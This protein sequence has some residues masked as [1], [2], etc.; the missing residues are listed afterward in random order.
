[1]KKTLLGLAMTL[2]LLSACTGGSGGNT[3]NGNTTN[4]TPT[5]GGF[6]DT[7]L[8]GSADTGS[9]SSVSE[10]YI[11]SNKT[12]ANIEGEGFFVKIDEAKEIF[13]AS[14]FLDNPH[15]I[16]NIRRK[17]L[18]VVRGVNHFDYISSDP[19]TVFMETKQ[20]LDAEN[21]I[22]SE[23]EYKALAK[24]VRALAHEKNISLVYYKDIRFSL[25]EVGFLCSAISSIDE[26]TE[27]TGGSV[28]V[29]AVHFSNDTQ[30]LNLGLGTITE[31]GT[32]LLMDFRASVQACA[33]SEKDIV[34]SDLQFQ[35]QIYTFA[36]TLSGWVANISGVTI[37][38]IP[39]L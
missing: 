20:S 35:E 25:T 4:F 2:T 33:G 16:E 21:T 14:R 19:M 24:Q 1:M 10:K 39:E 15:D 23:N 3:A 36:G 28:Y 37:Q 11:F 30:D 12:D 6:G 17:F 18:A 38:Q 8:Q 27:T 5:A 13:I 7:Q 32:Q 26:I 22:L 34:A 29:F 9:T 31:N